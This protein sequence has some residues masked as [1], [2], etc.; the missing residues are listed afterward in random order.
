M[1]AARLPTTAPPLRR[2]R[3]PR[4]GPQAQ[5]SP[6]ISKEVDAASVPLLQSHLR[7]GLFR[8]I[9]NAGICSEVAASD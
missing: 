7:N 4:G 8:H 9:V 2:P 1:K 3:I 5:G 6:R